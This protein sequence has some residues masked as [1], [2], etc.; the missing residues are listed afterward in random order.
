MISL[1][2]LP[3]IFLSLL[4]PLISSNCIQNKNCLAERGECI[5]NKCICYNEFWT[6]KPNSE[7]KLQNI[8]C[9]YAKKSRFLPLVL[10]FFIPGLGHIY[11]KKYILGI[12]KIF[13]WVSITILFFAG[14]YN[15]KSENEEE[16]KN[17]AIQNEEQIKLIN[18]DNN[19]ENNTINNM[20]EP[21][22]KNEYKKNIIEKMN[23]SDLSEEIENNN[24]IANEAPYI[25]N[26]KKIPISFGNKI[27]NL[28]E[29][30]GLI[31]FFILY[32]VDLF[33]YGFAF[34]KDSNNVP[35]L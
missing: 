35:L 31:C 1:N 33:A 12:F 8:F 16:K 14:Y 5:E 13:L 17:N 22:N 10:E 18:N 4:I 32:I 20:N 15:Y 9:N 6:L 25:A 2:F 27:L 28:F 29:F 3:I 30:I 7:N 11:M 24:N 34:Y 19:N 23:N 26:H 21:L